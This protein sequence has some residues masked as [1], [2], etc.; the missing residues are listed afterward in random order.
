[1]ALLEKRGFLYNYSG[2]FPQVILIVPSHVPNRIFVKCSL[3]SMKLTDSGNPFRHTL[4]RP[5]SGNFDS[6]NDYRKLPVILEN[7]IPKRA[8]VTRKFLIPITEN[9][10]NNQCTHMQRINAIIF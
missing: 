7:H 6:K 8:H 4:Q 2:D 9:L 5:Y 1:M 3:A 10:E